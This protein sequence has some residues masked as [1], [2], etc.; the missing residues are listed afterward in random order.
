M[1][2]VSYPKRKSVVHS[3]FKSDKT[4]P[5]VLTHEDKNVG[6]AAKIGISLLEW[7]RRDKLIKDQ[8]SKAKFK[9]GD[10]VYPASQ[11]NM[12]M[13]GRCLVVNVIDSY[14][15]CDHIER[16]P[17]TDIPW[18]YTLKPLQPSKGNEGNILVY[19]AW[20]SSLAPESVSK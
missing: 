9:F 11:E 6:R 2:S 10:T 1:I 12:D 14:K 4:K 13:Y 16:W 8:I 5:L 15:Q 3:L 7:E 20:V 17:E 18:M 19:P